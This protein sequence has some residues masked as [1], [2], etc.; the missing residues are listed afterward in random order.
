MSTAESNDLEF[1]LSGLAAHDGEIALGDLAAI[2]AALQQ[3]ATRIGRLATEQE[4]PGRSYAAVENATR[5]RLTGVG[6]GSTR[7]SIGYG[8]TDVLPVDDGLEQRTADLFWEVVSGFGSGHRPD[9]SS[10]LIDEAALELLDGLGRAAEVEVIR[11]DGRVTRFAPAEV[12]RTSWAH[13]DAEGSS[14]VEVAMTGRLEALDLDSGRF[15]LRD[16]VG[17]RIPI[18]H[19]KKPYAAA[20]FVGQEVTATGREVRAAGEFRGV[21]SPVVEPLVLPVEWSGVPVDWRAAFSRPGPDP[22]GGAD[23]TDE[24]FAAFLAAA[25]GD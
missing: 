12:D 20:A 9:W 16:D 11:Q 3:L 7:L 10:P 1:R 2:S 19:V 22:D 14:D 13:S 4:G 23:L 24:E 18:T 21:D 8:Q 15:R 6:L 5:L 17:N 25:K